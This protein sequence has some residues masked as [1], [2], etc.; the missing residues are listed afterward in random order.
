MNIE[1]ELSKEKFLELARELFIENHQY[2]SASSI[3]SP[4]H[5][6]L[7]LLSQLCNCSQKELSDDI[8]EKN[9]IDSIKLDQIEEKLYLE[10]INKVRAHIETK[11]FDF[12]RHAKILGFKLNFDLIEQIE[13]FQEQIYKSIKD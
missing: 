6:K 11:I 2:I 7:K 9:G 1:I 5:E 4:L 3:F 12:A 13:E 10:K 8:I